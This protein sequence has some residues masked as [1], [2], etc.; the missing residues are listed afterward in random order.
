MTPFP[1]KLSMIILG[2]CLLALTGCI[3]LRDEVPFSGPVH[4]F[5]IT[6][7]PV[8]SLV[9]FAPDS[10]ELTTAEQEKIQRALQYFQPQLGEKLA[11]TFSANADNQP[12]AAARSRAILQYLTSL[13]FEAGVMGQP[14]RLAPEQVALVRNVPHAS[15]P[16][17]PDWSAEPAPNYSNAPSGNFNCASQSNLAKMVVNPYDLQQG[18]SL[19]PADGEGSVLSIQRYRTDK[20]RE[21]LQETPTTLNK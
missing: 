11:V 8:Y 14:D 20:I 12:L 1:S 17:C 19:T 3:S 2:G 5:T 13:G 4:T 15:L 10:S 9:D 7:E 6:Q 18:R 16:G 21:L